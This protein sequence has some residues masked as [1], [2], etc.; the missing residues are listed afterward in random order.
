MAGSSLTSAGFFFSGFSS[1]IREMA[2]IVRNTPR[3]SPPLAHRAA[4]VAARRVRD[5]F[6]AFPVVVLE[7]ARGQKGGGVRVE[8]GGQV[9]DAQPSAVQHRRPGGIV[10]P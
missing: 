10:A 2:S 6:E 3:P 4:I 9:A 5:D 8:V 1:S 7:E